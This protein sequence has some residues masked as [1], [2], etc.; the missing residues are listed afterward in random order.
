MVDIS[1]LT[2][3]E[4]PL[5]KL[6]ETISQGIGVTGDA[7]F[8]L[9][10][11]KIKRI[12]EAEAQK[13]KEMIIKRAEAQAEATAILDRASRR[14]TLEQYD[15]QRNL[16]NIVYTS[17]EMLQGATVSDQP[18][19]KDWAMR[20]LDTAQE[21]SNEGIQYILAKI[22]AGEVTQPST[23][24]KRVL[25]V[26]KNVSQEELINFCK[27]V[28]YVNEK[29]AIYRGRLSRD[30]FFSKFELDFEEYLDLCDAG[31]MGDSDNLGLNFSGE[32]DTYIGHPHRHIH[33]SIQP[34][35]EI[36]INVIPLTI[37]GAQIANLMKERCSTP[38]N[39]DTYIENFTDELK[40]KGA[41]VVIDS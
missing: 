9:D 16:E 40:S 5:T 18:V 41:Q 22:L 35:T 8:K 2:G 24:S 4:K 3:F 20:F 13:E 39:I 38:R 19:D 34:G 17:S 11:K 28:P 32:E 31:L 29:G 27:F 30:G 33:I 23:Y 36:R 6:I 14:L 25:E 26:I 10:S 21:M 7:V 12:G 15:K 1:N 37:A